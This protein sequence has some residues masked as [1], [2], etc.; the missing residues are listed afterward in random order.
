M[1]WTGE[2]NGLCGSWREGWRRWR[3][4]DPSSDFCFRKSSNMLGHVWTCIDLGCV[5][6]GDLELR[7]EDAVDDDL[8][9]GV[10]GEFLTSQ[11][12]HVREMWDR[13]LLQVFL[14]GKQ[15]GRLPHRLQ[16]NLCTF[17]GH[18]FVPSPFKILPPANNITRTHDQCFSALDFHTRLQIQI[19]HT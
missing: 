3:C 14:F 12:C 9:D 11:R 10:E 19:T 2:S 6:V 5:G 7:C 1:F 17:C 16:L 8:S 13:S 4:G 18:R 15:I